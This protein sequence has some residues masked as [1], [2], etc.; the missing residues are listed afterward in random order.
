[1]LGKLR[2]RPSSINVPR[3]LFCSSNSASTARSRASSAVPNTTTTHLCST[4]L[5][6]LLRAQHVY[7]LR[8]CIVAKSSNPTSDA[9][10]S[11]TSC[12][13][14]GGDSNL[15]YN[16]L[17]SCTTSVILASAL[18]TV[19]NHVNAKFKTQSRTRN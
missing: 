19:D 16:A 2:K 13:S 18:S 3:R 11:H 12:N 6:C 4:Q 1:M 17:K 5:R 9:Q 10:H 15:A 7:D 8:S 14:C